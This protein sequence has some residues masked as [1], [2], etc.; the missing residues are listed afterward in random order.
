V[1]WNLQGRGQCLLNFARKVIGLRLKYPI[2][3]RDRF[4]NGE[5]LKDLDVKDVT[6]INA[7]GREMEDEHWGDN[8]MRCFG[9]LLDGRAQPSGIRKIGREATLLMVLNVYSD[10]VNFLMPVCVGGDEWSL[11]VDTNEPCKNVEARL[12][13]GEFYGV[14]AHSLLLFKLEA[15]Q[16]VTGS[17]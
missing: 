14:T 17:G 10:L 13:T 16:P 8:G 4:L 11:L 15:S 5:Y 6:W 1:N 9:M 3:R 12:K 2:L 7:N